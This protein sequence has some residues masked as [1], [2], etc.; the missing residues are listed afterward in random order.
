MKKGVLVVVSLA[1]FIA[2]GIGAI[3][4]YLKPQTTIPSQPEISVAPFEPQVPEK[5]FVRLPNAEPIEAMKED[6]KL[7][8]SLWLVLSKDHP[9]ADPN[10]IP[11]DLQ[12]L[13]TIATRSDKSQEERSLRPVA[14]EYL[15]TML[16]DAKTAGFELM[17]GSAFRSFTLQNFYYSNY[18]KTAGEATANLYSAKP[19][20]SEHQTGLVVDISLTSRACYLETCFGQTEA[21]KWLAINATKYGFILRYPENKTDITKYQYEPW[22]FRYVGQPLATALEKSGLTLDEAY[23][24]LE[25]ARNELIATKLLTAQ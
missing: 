19:G 20:E 5:V 15:T 12:L 8:S 2:I 18:V 7:P 21:G 6:F 17:V 3:Y 23:P 24:Y 1:V 4:A 22:H 25:S 10:Y 14:T 9:I 13:T 11:S 16:N